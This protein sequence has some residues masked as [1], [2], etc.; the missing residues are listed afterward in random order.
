[1]KH[2]DEFNAST[3]SYYLRQTIAVDKTQ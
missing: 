1:M 3:M 2:I